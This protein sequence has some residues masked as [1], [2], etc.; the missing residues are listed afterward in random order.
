MKCRICGRDCP[1]GA[2]ICRDCAAARKRAFAQ[3]VTQPLLAA[4]GAPSVAEP[5]F[6]PKPRR[7][8][9]NDSKVER[10][11]P[12]AAPAAALPLTSVPRKLGAL[13]LAVGLLVVAAIALL[14]WRT[15]ASRGHPA[16][17][18]VA[19]VEVPAVTMPAPPPA[20]IEQVAPERP[21]SEPAKLAPAKPRRFAPHV[22]PALPVAAAPAPAP[23]P[24]PVVRPPAPAPRAVEAPRPDP[25]QALNE[26][27]SRCAHE[28]LFDRIACEQRVRL[29]YCG[30]SWGVAPQCPIGPASD[31]GQ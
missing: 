8:A 16:E 10:A 2:K 5:R 27:L 22:E 6:A 25:M 18:G 14:L 28:A 23:E 19:A 29:Q 31:H 21:M 7:R 11:A 26:G 1:P 15:V 24:A 17:D 13:W 20:D 9:A 3:T 30:N 4:V 12:Q